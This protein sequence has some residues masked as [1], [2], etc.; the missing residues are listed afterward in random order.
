MSAVAGDCRRPRLSAQLS[1]AARARCSRAPTSPTSMSTGPA[2]SG[3][4]RSAARSS[5]T[6]RPALDEATLGASRPP[7]RRAVASGDQPRASLAVGHPA[8]RRARPDRRAAGDARPAGAGDPQACLARSRRSPIMSRPAR[9]PRRGAATS[10]S[11][12]DVDRALAALLDAGDIAGMLAAAVAGAQEHPG[13]GRHLDRQDD[14]PQRAAPRDSGRGAADPDRGHARAPAPATP[15]RRPA[16]R[17]QRAGRG[18][19]HAPTTCS[20]PRCACVPTGSSWASCA[21][22][23]PMPSCARSI[24]AIPAR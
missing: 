6:T 8:R 3:S 18:A 17:A 11:A 13:L 19:G 4:R 23:R 5:A 16:R 24:P 2:R 9:S 14:L 1:R 10:A 20:R 22:R 12:R 21:A 15:T 7:D